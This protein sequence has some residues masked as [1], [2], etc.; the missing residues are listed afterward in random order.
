MKFTH[1]SIYE[2]VKSPVKVALVWDAW[3]CEN[4]V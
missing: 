1:S 2:M 4:S 3:A